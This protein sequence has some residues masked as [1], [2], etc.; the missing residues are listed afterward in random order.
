M[1]KLLT[2]LLVLIAIGIAALGLAAGE[3]GDRDEAHEKE[4]EG[5]LDRNDAGERA[6]QG[7]VSRAAYLSEPG[8]AL[9]ETECGSCHMAFPPSM[10]PAAS[11]Q[12]MMGNLGDHF[13]D[14]AEL[15]S[16]IAG[17]IA[18][19][20][21]RNAA[22]DGRGRYA[23]GAWRSTRG[24]TPPLRITEM[25]YF[26]GQHHEIPAQMVK[27]SPGVGSFARC[28]SCHAGAKQGDFDERG[29]RIPG[30]S[31]WDD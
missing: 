19:F 7:F 8:Y 2:P 21:A 29:V 27:G 13:G 5:E 3:F 28:E 30:Y 11:W 15:D 18:G 4:R 9:Y 14:N 1:K 24:Q 10:L 31:H 25:D 12:A 16:R 22:G 20:L 26:R 6:G 17:Q 23:E